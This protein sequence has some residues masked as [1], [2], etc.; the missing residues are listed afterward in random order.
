MIQ[1]GAKPPSWILGVD[2][3][4]LLR[5]VHDGSIAQTSAQWTSARSAVW[6]LFLFAF[7]HFSSYASH[8]T[9]GHLNFE[10]GRHQKEGKGSRFPGTEDTCNS[11]RGSSRLWGSCQ[12]KC[13]R[14]DMGTVSAGSSAQL[15]TWPNG[16]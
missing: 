9:D 2:G 6:S 12:G 7:A 4:G 11:Q 16:S 3:P 1:S 8:S 10:V 15:H 13:Y 14:H 5:E